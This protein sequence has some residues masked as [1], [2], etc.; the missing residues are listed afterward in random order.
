MRNVWILMNKELR[1]FYLTPIAHVISAFFLFFMA[2]IFTL[3]IFNDKTADI[4]GVITTAVVT[5]LLIAP[6]ITMRLFAEEKKTGTIEL[7]LT[8]PVSDWEVVLGKYFSILIFFLA[9]V[10]LTSQFPLI[11]IYYSSPDIN[12]ICSSYIGLILV[13]SAFISVGVMTSSMCKNQIIAAISSFSILLILW[14]IDETTQILPPPYSKFSEY[15]SIYSHFDNFIIGK[16][17]TSDIIFFFSFIFFI[18]FLTTRIVESRKW[19]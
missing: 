16:I 14:F 9:L 15:I 13:G 5:I 4:R 3:L 7:L 18:L 17:D 8:N 11:L 12:L 19:R 2:L 10:S 6:V 1:S